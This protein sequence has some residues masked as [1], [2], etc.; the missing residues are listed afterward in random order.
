V[1][2]LGYQLGIL[3]GIPICGALFGIKLMRTAAAVVAIG[4][5]I[6]IFTNWLL[7]LQLVTLFIAWLIGE[8]I[9]S[10]SNIQAVRQGAWGLVIFAGIGIWLL[11]KDQVT[12]QPIRVEPTAR[13]EPL[14]QSPSTV[15]P[16]QVPAE[17]SKFSPEMLAVI[18]RLEA[19]FPE[20][21]EKSKAFDPKLVQS[22]FERQLAYTN[23][24]LPP[25]MALDRAAREAHFVR[26]QSPDSEILKRGRGIYWE[27][28]NKDG[29]V[30]VSEKPCKR[31]Q[32]G[33]LR[34]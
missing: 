20:F 28:I 4:T 13:S 32:R 3:F 22:A 16:P 26:Y 6:A 15:T 10:A 5:C 23:Q 7:A 30:E 9:A 18:S 34:N 31:N 27:C 11:A 29:S 17:N 25:E 1:E 21:N 12:P 19:E 33:T 8:G 24:G 14:V 2:V